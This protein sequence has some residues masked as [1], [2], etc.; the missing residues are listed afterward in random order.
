MDGSEAYGR[1]GD[2]DEK[3]GEEGRREF[4]SSAREAGRVDLYQVRG[5]HVRL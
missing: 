4:S 5:G 3:E 2:A 1:V